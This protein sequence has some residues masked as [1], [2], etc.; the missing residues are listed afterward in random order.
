MEKQTRNFYIQHSCMDWNEE[1]L[2]NIKAEI[3]ELEEKG[4]THIEIDVG[5]NACF[6]TPYTLRMET[7]EEFE[8]RINKEK[9][10]S[11]WQKTY[12][13]KKYEEI[14]AKYKL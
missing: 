7:D 9:R 10:M 4:A 13:I 11:E 2:E 12:D 3:A 8:E 6:I 14:K 5:D 1:S